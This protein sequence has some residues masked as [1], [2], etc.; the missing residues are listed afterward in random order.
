M[1]K[2]SVLSLD[3]A[4]VRTTNPE[5]LP[6]Q[7]PPG[8]LRLTNRPLH[9]DFWRTYQRPGSLPTTSQPAGQTR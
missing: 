1:D 6:E 4:N 5:V 9:E 8:N 3:Y 7:V 2:L